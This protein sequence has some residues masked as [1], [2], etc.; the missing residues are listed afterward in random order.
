MRDEREGEGK[1][2]DRKI[3]LN[4][5]VLLDDENNNVKKTALDFRATHS[6]EKEGMS[7]YCI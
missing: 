3:S 4:M 6:C 7:S 1:P 5:Q 2:G